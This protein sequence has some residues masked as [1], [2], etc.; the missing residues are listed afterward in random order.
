[1]LPRSASSNTKMQSELR[2]ALLST[3]IVLIA[4]RYG[5]FHKARALLDNGSQANIISKKLSAK[6]QIETQSNNSSLVGIGQVEGKSTKMGTF[7]IKSTASNYTSKTYCHVLQNI[8]C[9][10]P[11]CT[12]NESLVYLLQGIRQISMSRAK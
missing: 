10:V 12:F 4:G 1:M 7:V 2:Q 9:N 5:D 8:A 11:T 3:A 6:L